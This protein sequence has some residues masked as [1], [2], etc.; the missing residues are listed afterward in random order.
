MIL[1]TGAA[2]QVGSVLVKELVQQGK[3]VKAIVTETDDLRSLE[4]ELIEVVVGDVRDLQFLKREFVGAEVV[5]HLAGIVSITSGEKEIIEEVNVGGTKNVIQACKAARVG[6]LI[7]TSSVHPFVELPHGQL[8]DESAPIDPKKVLGD[9]AKSKAKATLLVKEAVN[10]VLDAVIVYPSG[11][12]GPYAYS[13]SNMGQLFIDYV[14]GKIPVMIEGTYDFVDVRDLVD[15]LLKAWRKAKAGENYILSGYQITLKQI[16]YILAN[17]TGRKPPRI[18]IPHWFLKLLVPLIT[19]INRLSKK[20]PTLTSYALYTI[21]SNSLFSH[22]KARE[23]LGYKPRHLARTLED[24][25][26]WY[27]KIE[28]L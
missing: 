7:Y 14:R 10:E 8:I 17:I 25:I 13:I 23:D 18:Y 15:G 22:E 27:E 2:G 1:V 12:I 6:R 16:F 4:N 21:S 19:W 24:T 5:F 9:Y 26:A 28:K 20:T 3:Q 11:I